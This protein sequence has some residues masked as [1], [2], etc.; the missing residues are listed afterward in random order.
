M[1]EPMISVAEALTRVLAA[2]RPVESE[3]VPLAQAFGRTLAAPV[4]AGRTQPPFANSAM[5]GYALRAR[6]AATPGARLRLI[7]E[8]AAGRGFEGE[9]G[10][11]ETARIFTGA[12]LPPGADAIAVQ[13][14]ARRD[15]DFVVFDSAAKPGDHVRLV[16]LDFRD[17]DALLAAGRRLSPRDVALIAA[18]NRPTATVRRKPRV[19]ILATGDELRSPGQTLGPA[20]I[21][22]SNNFFVAGLSQGLGAEAIDLGI[23]PDRPEALA[24]RIAA[25]RSARADVLVTLGGA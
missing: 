4:V 7:G 24:E 14:D 8:S 21:V 12:P 15:G 18:A 20:Q 13:E 6:D 1:K 9:I 3:E 11:G 5:D 25:A 16:G 10:P 19:A 2:A 23:A 22:A 17:G